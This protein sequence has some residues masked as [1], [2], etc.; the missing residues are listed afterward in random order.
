MKLG[1]ALA[2]AVLLT[3]FAHFPAASAVELP[4]RSFYI[5]AIGRIHDASSSDPRVWLEYELVDWKDPGTGSTLVVD[6]SCG[7]RLKYRLLGNRRHNYLELEA[8]AGAAPGLIRFDPAKVELKVGE[9]PELQHGTMHAPDV[10]DLAAG[11]TLFAALPFPDK[12]EFKG[13]SK[14][15]ARIS[16]GTCTAEV[17]FKR[18]EGVSERSE[19]SRI[20][21]QMQVG[22]E[23]GSGVAKAGSLSSQASNGIEGALTVTRYPWL[24]QGFWLGIEFQSLGSPSGVGFLFGYSFRHYVSSRLTFHYD[25]APGV[26]ELSSSSGLQPQT[27]DNALF[28]SQRIGFDFV[29]GRLGEPVFLDSDHAVGIVFSDDWLPSTKIDGNS[30]AGQNFSLLFRY[31]FE[32]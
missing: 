16:F 24:S 3:S 4:P 13:Q 27:L 9:G 21:S 19:S 12:T 29:F 8:Q 7:L 15:S 11:D 5:G 2:F 23:L 18:P 26:Y 20:W 30:A 32:L 25:I 31:L 28:L 6:R 14:I 10:V 1:L 17:V 22:L